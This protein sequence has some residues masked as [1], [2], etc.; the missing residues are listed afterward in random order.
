MSLAAIGD[1][2]GD[3]RLQFQGER[4]NSNAF[5]VALENPLLSTFVDLLNTAGLDDIFFCA[6]MY[7]TCGLFVSS[8]LHFLSY[9]FGYILCHSW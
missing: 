1:K 3:R 9:T 2:N 7:K 5:D 4:C 8:W 6:G